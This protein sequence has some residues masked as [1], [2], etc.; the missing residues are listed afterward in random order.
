MDP[1]DSLFARLARSTFRARFRLG[2]K[3]RQY[4]ID[5]G[6]EV[7]DRHAA[8]F[9]ASRLAP[10]QPKNDGKQTPMRGHPVFIAQH[11]TATCCRG[12]LQKWHQ[13]PQGTPLSEEQ[14]QYIVAVI[15]HWLVIQMNSQ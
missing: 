7:I 10:A 9:I 15:H 4:C 13:I 12:C 14:Q 2:P 3:E 1:L 5:K 6:P 11:A 8:D